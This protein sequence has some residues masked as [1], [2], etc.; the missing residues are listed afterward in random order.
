LVV[1]A[2]IGPR[3]NR[4]NRQ[5]GVTNVFVILDPQGSPSGIREQERRWREGEH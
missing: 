2:Y 3:V 1:L 4:A 5:V